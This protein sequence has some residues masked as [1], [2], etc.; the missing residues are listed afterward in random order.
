MATTTSNTSKFVLGVCGV[1]VVDGWFKAASPGPSQ[2]DKTLGLG[3]I[4]SISA[5]LI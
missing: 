4:L 3:A 5:Y 1:C 2:T